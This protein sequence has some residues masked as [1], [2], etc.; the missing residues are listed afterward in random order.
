MQFRPIAPLAAFN[1]ADAQPGQWYKRPNGTLTQYVGSRTCPSGKLAFHFCD[2]KP[3]E[4]FVAR[5][6]RFARARWHLVHRHLGLQH[7]VERAPASVDN[8]RLGAYAR[9]IVANT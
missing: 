1:G 2:A 3:G 8:A 9:A 6:Q 7:M 5:T 4:T